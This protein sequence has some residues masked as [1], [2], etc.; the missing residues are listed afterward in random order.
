[1]TILKFG[2][3]S[4][5]NS[6]MIKKVKE[7]VEEIKDEKIVVVSA[8]AGITDSL[9]RATEFAKSDSDDFL[10]EF[11]AIKNRHRAVMNELFKENLKEVEEILENLFNILTSIRV[12]GEVTKR[13]MDLILSFGERMNARIVSEF[14]KRNG[15][16]SI[17]VDANLFLITDDN[18]G[19]ANP[20]YEKSKDLFDK[21]ILPLVLDG[22]VPVVT[23]FIGRTED[24]YI[25]TLGRGGSDFS[26][27]IIGNLSDADEVRIYT[28]VDGV[29][30]G[31]PKFIKNA[32]TIKNLSYIEAAEL[33]YYG[34]KVL[35]PRSLLPVID[36][37]IPVRILNTFNPKNEG[38]LIFD[39]ID[40]KKVIK[41]ITFVKDISLISV[42][43]KGMLGVPGIS[44][45]VFKN[46][47][48]LK[49]NVLMISQ[50]SSEQ[51]ICFVVKREESEKLISRLN[52]EF[53]NEIKNRL[54]DGIFV[55]YEVSIISIIGAKMK[56]RYG[57]AGKIFSI[58]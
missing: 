57:I 14:F 46:A 11:D 18:F 22:V 43:G 16:K 49:S 39:S 3:T 8:M 21:L 23:G 30:T 44:Y 56:G 31:D 17:P 26:A 53:K 15:I 29:L 51:N 28:D 52:E 10:K 20:D 5:G 47:Y 45:R 36:K 2:G 50:S 54:I 38:T 33:S 7:I 40:D 37:K 1:M 27:T 13:A 41:A 32:K 48:E 35:H 6:E 4:V 42:N 25:T 24:G 19:N 55:D 12:L 9:I 34:A 58:L